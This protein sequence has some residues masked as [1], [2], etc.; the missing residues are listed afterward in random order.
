MDG[1]QEVSRDSLDFGSHI[2]W[3]AVNQG[4]LTL[5]FSMKFLTGTFVPNE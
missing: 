1:Q 4:V 5:V 2:L 3:H